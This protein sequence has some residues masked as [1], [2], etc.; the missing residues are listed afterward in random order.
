[1][2][3]PEVI[4]DVVLGRVTVVPLLYKFITQKADG[5]GE[6]LHMMPLS[7]PVLSAL[8]ALPQDQTMLPTGSS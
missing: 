6:H 7:A 8:K 2:T 1:M 4:R 5:Q 3:S